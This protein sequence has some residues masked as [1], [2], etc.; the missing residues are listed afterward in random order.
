MIVCRRLVPAVLI[1]I[2]MPLSGHAQ[3]PISSGGGTIAG[4]VTDARAVPIDH[5]SVI[6]F[7]TDR[8]KWTANPRSIRFA[9]PSPDGGFE[10]ADLP[11]GEYWV[12]AV[13]AISGNQGGGDWQKPD[14][15]ESLA[16]RATRVVLGE[17]ERYLT[18]LRLI[19]R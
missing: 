18:V 9:A 16:P 13:D 19:R 17:H 3:Q 14:V 15:L 5:Y 11:P 6:V 7:S 10:V 8:A 12:A 1:T 4:H 2:V